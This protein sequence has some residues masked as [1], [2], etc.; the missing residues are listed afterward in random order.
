M[1][2][3][4]FPL[5]RLDGIYKERAKCLKEWG[6]KGPVM[7]GGKIGLLHFFAKTTCIR[8]KACGGQI[9]PGSRRVIQRWEG[10]VARGG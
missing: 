4:I 9:M 1:H 3:A 5:G 7:Q 2:E 8:D 6:A 10:V